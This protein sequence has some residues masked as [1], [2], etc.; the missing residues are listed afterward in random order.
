MSLKTTYLANGCFWCTEAVF[1]RIKG[2]EEVT[3]GF[4][5]GSIKHPAY[6]EVVEGRTGQEEAIRIVFDDEVISFK[7]LLYVFFYTHDPTT[8]NRQGYDIGTQYRSAIF[9]VDEEQRNEALSVVEELTNLRIFDKPIVT[10]IS[11]ASDF[12]AADEDHQNFYNLNKEYRYCQLV[13][14]PKLNTLQQKFKQLLN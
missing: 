2:V 10:E 12:Y 6:R 3:S 7:D 5:G 14:D 9:Y 13:I 11:A 8:L 4:T 1:Q